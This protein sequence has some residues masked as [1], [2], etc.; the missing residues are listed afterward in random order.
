MWQNIQDSLLEQ[1][2]HSLQEDV[3]ATHFMQQILAPGVLSQ[4][5]LSH[6]LLELEE[7]L[8]RYNASMSEVQQHL[9]AA[10][11]VSK[12]PNAPSLC[13]ST[14]CKLFAG[15]DCINGSMAEG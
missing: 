1:T 4:Q 12:P 9:T 3:L 13:V 14:T 5:A 2:G 8:A 7:P 11:Q 10:A 6:A 15:Q